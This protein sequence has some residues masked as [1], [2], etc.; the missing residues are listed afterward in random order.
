VIERPVAGGQQAGARATRD[1]FAF[2]GGADILARLLAEEMGRAQK[3]YV[4]VED[5]PGGGTVPTTEA[6]AHA[7]P[8]GGTLLMNANSF[9]FRI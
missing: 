8:D 5:R 1:N 2:S 3:I 6:V 4:V 7:A 9:V